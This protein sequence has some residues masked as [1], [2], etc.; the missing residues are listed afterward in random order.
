MY[1]IGKTMQKQKNKNKV[2]SRELN[3]RGAE[4]EGT[5][6]DAFVHPIQVNESSVKIEM[7]HDTSLQTDIKEEN[8]ESAKNIKD[9][10]DSE[11]FKEKNVSEIDTKS[12]QKTVSSLDEDEKNTSAL[13]KEISLKNKNN[14]ESMLEET[15][16]NTTMTKDFVD[17]ISIFRTKVDNEI[18]PSIVV[19]KNEENSKVSGLGSICKDSDICSNT[20]KSVSSTVITKI[21]PLLKYTYSDDQW[22]PINTSGKKIYGR[23]FL[24]KLQN[25]P[26]SKA[27]PSNLPDLDVVLKDSTKIRSPVDLWF[28][29]T[30]LGRHDSL[31]PGFVKS[32][33]SAKVVS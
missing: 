27:K 1:F 8:T 30:N 33:V 2:K 23:E 12:V 14:K 31:F 10:D 24:M 32:S 15:L 16:V 4:K 26:N 9:K 20:S 29:D 7:K 22:S 18:I 13:E 19:Q 11:F 21:V 25:D 6:M 5:D 3:R 17:H 28:K